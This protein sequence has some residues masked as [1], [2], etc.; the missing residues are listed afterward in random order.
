MSDLVFILGLLTICGFGLWTWRIDSVQRLDTPA[1]LSIAFSSGMVTISAAMFLASVVH[2]AWS[3]SLFVILLALATLAAWPAISRRAGKWRPRL[4]DAGILVIAL[5]LAYGV[6]TARLTCADLLFFWGPK[7]AHFQAV[8]GIDPAFLAN[9]N[10]YLMHPDYPPL[11]PAVYAYAAT[12]AQRM[13]WWGTLLL[14]PL[15]LLAGVASFRGLAAPKIGEA[16]AGRYALALAA[17]MAMIAVGSSAAGG[18]DP[19]IWLFTVIGVSALV[20]D[21][22]NGGRAI[23]VI[24]L[25]GAAFTKVEGTALAAI[26]IAAYAVTTRRP[27]AAA[28]LAIAPAILLGSWLTYAA[29][30]RLLDSYARSGEPL[31][32]DQLA[33]VLRQVA[34]SS[35]YRVWWLPWAVALLLILFISNWRR[36]AFPL[37][38]S[39]GTFAA[40]IYFYLH[41]ADPAFWIRTSAE[42]VLGATVLCL[43][44]AS[45]AAEEL[46]IEN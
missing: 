4:T 13:S 32:S 37:A 21:E 2:L 24:A 14:T 11:L 1:R 22:S 36:A 31:H 15:S 33:P 3:R 10:Y 45:A 34:W 26:I 43:F 7:A 6:F 29:H 23:A 42:R 17:L 25:C 27:K 5:V 19:L 40:T 39:L 41:S 9:P 35:S 18:A 44:L 28:A 20:F 8:R 16:A 46:R 30:Y 12:L 38:V